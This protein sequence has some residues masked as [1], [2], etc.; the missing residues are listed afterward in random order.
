M[1]DD[2][3]VGSD[4]NARGLCLVFSRSPELFFDMRVAMTG[5]K[6][7]GFDTSDLPSGVGIGQCSLGMQLGFVRSKYPDTL[8]LLLMR[9]DLVGWGGG[10]TDAMMGLACCVVKREFSWGFLELV[11]SVN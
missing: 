6:V 2:N 4:D 7:S 9:E 1:E 5:G 3:P 10:S 8:M 11:M